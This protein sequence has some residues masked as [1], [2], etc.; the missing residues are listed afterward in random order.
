MLCKCKSYET[1]IEN[2]LKTFYAP[3]YSSESRTIGNNLVRK[4][5]I[6]EWCVEVILDNSMM[7]HILGEFWFWDKF[8]CFCVSEFIE[9]TQRC[10]ENLDF[11][12]NPQSVIIFMMNEWTKVIAEDCVCWVGGW[13]EM[14][15]G[16]C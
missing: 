10:L 9:S 2:V 6:M 7:S 16:V 12:K 14:E 1:T 5:P 15:K 8:L 4:Q 3:V 11:P 13:K